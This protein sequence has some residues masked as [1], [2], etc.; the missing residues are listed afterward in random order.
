MEL[1]QHFGD[2]QSI[3]QFFKDKGGKRNHMRLSV[4]TKEKFCIQLV[5]E[6]GLEISH[7]Q[8]TLRGV[9]L[10]EIV[11]NDKTELYINKS[12]EEVLSQKTFTG[13]TE[14]AF[15]IMHVSRHHLTRNFRLQFTGVDGKVLQ[16]TAPICVRSK[17]K[18]HQT[19]PKNSSGPQGLKRKRT[20]R[21]KV[22]RS[23]TT[24]PTKKGK[25][26]HALDADNGDDDFV[27]VDVFNQ[28][29]EHCLQLSRRVE[30]L[31]RRVECINRS[32]AHQAELAASEIG[33]LSDRLD[34]AALH[35]S[36]LLP[37]EI[38]RGLL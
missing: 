16:Q 13:D 38:V 30:Y 26:Q 2:E 3:Y 17:L 14:V 21:Q 32:A 25:T 24:Q 31:S 12:G 19:Y 33:V 4:K 37:P 7:E 5:F 6:N 22:K 8:L 20:V 34:M 28:L 11:V 18:N 15:R 10:L 27:H 36:E 9:P 1:T 29:L 23:N 35:N